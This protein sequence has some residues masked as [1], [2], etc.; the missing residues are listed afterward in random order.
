VHKIAAVLISVYKHTHT[1][2]Q[3]E[4]KEETF[5]RPKRSCDE[6]RS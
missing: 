2:T 3:T 5:G 1:Y 6:G 4:R